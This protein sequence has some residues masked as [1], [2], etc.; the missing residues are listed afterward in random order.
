M[1]EECA[2]LTK[3]RQD[4]QTPK[5]DEGKKSET[6]RNCTMQTLKKL[7]KV[8]S[9]N[10]FF[11]YFLLLFGI[12]RKDIHQLNNEMHK[13]QSQLVDTDEVKD[14]DGSQLRL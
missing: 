2:L 11:I 4:L 3:R 14:S 10:I 7:A 6:H 8:E 12:T 9:K 1:R 5:T 13:T